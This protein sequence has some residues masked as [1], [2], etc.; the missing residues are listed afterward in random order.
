MIGL[1]TETI[2]HPT[3]IEIPFVP[4]TQYPSADY[5]LPIEPG[6]WHFRQSVEYSQTA[7]WAVL[8]YASRNRDLPAVQHLAHGDELHRAGQPGQLDHAAVRDRRGGRGDEPR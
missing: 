3:P 7:N 8:D 5:P 2:G 1:L 6:P 4:R